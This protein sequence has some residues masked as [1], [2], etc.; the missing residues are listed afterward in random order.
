MINVKAKEIVGWTT[1]LVPLAAVVI[2]VASMAYTPNSHLKNKYGR[3]F[4][5]FE[6]VV[7]PTSVANENRTALEES[8]SKKMI[9]MARGKRDSIAAVERARNDS[10]KAAMA[11]KKMKPRAQAPKQ[12]VRVPQKH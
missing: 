6:R 4:S 8:I 5:V 10:I 2:G 3:N 7:M 9:E 12:Q 1:L 11:M